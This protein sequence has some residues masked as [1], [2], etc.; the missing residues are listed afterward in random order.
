MNNH[1]RHG[2]GTSTLKMCWHSFAPR[3]GDTLSQNIGCLPGVQFCS[4]LLSCKLH[5]AHV[6]VPIQSGLPANLLPLSARSRTPKQPL[7]PPRHRH[8]QAH[9]QH[10]TRKPSA[11]F[12]VNLQSPEAYIAPNVPAKLPLR[13]YASTV[14]T[15]TV[16]F[17]TLP[18]DLL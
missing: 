14:S 4:V 6:Y 1:A 9:Q 13:C 15:A 7:E 16:S 2:Q 10:C 18:L 17:R 3:S 11:R 8:K 12:T 5:P